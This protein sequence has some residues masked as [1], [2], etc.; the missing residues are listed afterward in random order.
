MPTTI[1][2]FLLTPL[3]KQFKITILFAAFMFVFLLSE[4]TLNDLSKI[5][6]GRDS[7]LTTYAM[8]SFVTALGY[9]FFSFIEQKISYSTEFPIYL[10]SFMCIAMLGAFTLE[11][12]FFSTI[13]YTYMF[14]LGGLGCN[15][16]FVAS[17]HLKGSPYLGRVF[18]NAICLAVIAQFLVQ[19]FLHGSAI[20]LVLLLGILYLLYTFHVNRTE[21]SHVEYNHLS[22]SDTP[23]QEGIVQIIAVVLMSLVLS[24]ND[25]IITQY[26]A[27]GIISVAEWPR[28]FYAIG[29][30][31][32]GMITDIKNR[33]FL[34]LSA[35]SG[36]LLLTIA[37]S[38]LRSPELFSLNLALMYFSGS[39]YI[40]YLTVVFVELAPRTSYPKLWAGMGRI[41][42]GVS[43]GMVMAISH[44]LLNMELISLM[45][46]DICLVFLLLLLLFFKDLLLPKSLS[47]NHALQTNEQKFQDFVAYFN[48]TP[49]E[50]DVLHKV[51]TSGDSGTQ[52]A[53]EL[54]IS[55]RVF[56]RHLT[57]IYEKTNTKS[58]IALCLL[59]YRDE[60]KQDKTTTLSTAPNVAE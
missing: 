26:H 48:F 36:L 10:C 46:I 38:F 14:F 45:L 34:P 5:Y 49:R 6:L 32:A 41:A 35:L 29:I 8:Y 22:L 60:Y 58:R 21:P 31:C 16:F 20:I 28:L 11:L 7:V 57:A 47:I 19:K 3:R 59:F 1:M 43:V 9:I 2:D 24:I 4:L 54:L 44:Y 56:Q 30:L 42:R 33:L 53:K 52:L 37:F 40:I 51:L 27:Q 18:G 50:E 25:G 55:D 39:F 13:V 23:T 17:Q 15:A 12:P